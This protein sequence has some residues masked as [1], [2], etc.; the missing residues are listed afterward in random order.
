VLLT[1]A[2]LDH[3]GFLPRL[4]REGFKGRILCT[5]PTHEIAKIVLLD[6]ARIQEEDAH[7]KKRRHKREGRKARHPEVAL[8]N[9]KDA[10]RTFSL[11]KSVKYGEPVLIDRS[12]TTTFYD[13]GHIL[14]SA[15]IKVGFSSQRKSHT[16][17]FSGDVGRWKKPILKDPTLLDQADY[18]LVE[19]TYGD[20]FHEDS[21]GIKMRL[22]E[23]I[24]S[25]VERGGNVVIPSFALERTQE[26][27]YYLSELL[28]EDRIPHLLTLWTAPWPSA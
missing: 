5:P 1:H 3:C 18:V 4:V 23:A 20:R 24:N 6:A 27:L 26:L 7:F 25:T 17:I 11:F 8:Y 12:V 28:R 9:K 14:G 10:K 22:C 19:S 2:H 21:S 13:A 15:M 16:I